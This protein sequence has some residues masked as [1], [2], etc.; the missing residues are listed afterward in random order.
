VYSQSLLPPDKLSAAIHMMQNAPSGSSLG[1]KVD[2][3]KTARMDFSSR[4]SAHFWA[5]CPTA[6]PQ[7][8]SV[9]LAIIRISPEAKQPVFMMEEFPV[10]K[11]APSAGVGLGHSDP[12]ETK[13]FMGGFALGEGPYS[14]DVLFLDSH[15][16]V[17][18]KTLKLSVP[19]SGVGINQLALGSGQVAELSFSTWDGKFSP[20]GPRIT[21]LLNANSEGGSLGAFNIAHPG[22]TGGE[23]I[24]AYDPA[25]LLTILGSLLSRLSCSSATIVA[26][27][28]DRQL[29]VF[30]DENVRVSTFGSLEHALLGRELQTIDAGALQKGSRE[31]FLYGL[32][33]KEALAAKRPDIVLLL[34]EPIFL[35]TKKAESFAGIDNDHIRFF[36]L[37]SLNDSSRLQVPYPDGI[38]QM[39]KLLH[40]KTLTFDS[41]ETL[42]SAIETVEHS[43]T[44]TSGN[45]APQ[46]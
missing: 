11:S 41:P 1:C 27:D 29:E 10:S 46:P 45:D 14:I 34:G 37:K 28:I 19:K 42:T 13:F 39:M 36:Y 31:D 44:Q 5:E 32:V 21:V 6:V 30:R 18:R 2:I 23:I 25:Y 24:S 38:Q 12:S 33:R 20:A 3:E 15:A 35:D 22:A 7:V 43:K 9:L 8:G 17:G 40:G 16:H 26:Y 4:Y